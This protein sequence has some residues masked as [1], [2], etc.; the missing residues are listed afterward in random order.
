MYMILVYFWHFAKTD[1]SFSIKIYNALMP[2]LRLSGRFEILD[3]DLLQSPSPAFFYI[4]LVVDIMTSTQKRVS[5]NLPLK[6]TRYYP[7]IIKLAFITF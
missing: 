6:M 4:T 3:H 5:G 2:R 1:G 7:V